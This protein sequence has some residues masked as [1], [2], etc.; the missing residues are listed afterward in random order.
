M[1]LNTPS[2]ISPFDHVGFLSLAS[3]RRFGLD[4]MLSVCLLYVMG[5]DEARKACEREKRGMIFL[6]AARFPGVSDGT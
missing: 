4:Q 6:V 1:L 3:V 2:Y 5:A